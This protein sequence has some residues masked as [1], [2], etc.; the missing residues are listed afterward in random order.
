MKRWFVVGISFLL[1]LC[2]LLF[3]GAPAQAQSIGISPGS[4]EVYSAL[5]G[6]TYTQVLTIINGQSETLAFRLSPAGEAA[7]WVTLYTEADPFVPI[8]RIEAPPGQDTR[9]LVKVRVPETAPTRLHLAGVQI[10]SAPVDEEEESGVTG[11]FL[12]DVSIDVTGTQHLAGILTDVSVPDTEVGLPIRALMTFANR[13]NV[14]AEPEID[15]LIVNEAGSLVGGLTEEQLPVDVDAE[16]DL[17]AEWPT[18]DQQV[19]LYRVRVTV[20][21][22]E[23]QIYQEP[24][25]VQLWPEGTFTRQGELDSLELGNEPQPGGIAEVV[26]VF[27][28][29]GE[30][31]TLAT[32]QG[33]VSRGDVLVGTASSQAEVLVL[34]G[35]SEELAVFVDVPEKGKYTLEG[36]V[37]Y[38]GKET[39]PRAV[40]FKVPPDLGSGF[41]GRPWWQW[42]IGSVL[43]LVV[44]GVSTVEVR[45]WRRQQQ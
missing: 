10:Q 5:R 30:I 16:A 13:S 2:A 4:L 14:V 41:L 26:A 1:A 37:N 45:R 32:F 28:N 24:F 22:Q 34:S 44:V 36:L 27:R 33:Q 31:E 35:E 12:V 25:D 18:A 42:G 21:L 3:S 43:A 6:G 9:F 40:T 20:R 38:E 11:G 17:R 29:T 15:L 39:D 7:S 23:T 8:S 19:G